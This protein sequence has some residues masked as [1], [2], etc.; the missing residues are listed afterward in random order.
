VMTGGLP[1]I[2]PGVSEAA[3]SGLS[4]ITP[5]YSNPGGVACADED[6]EEEQDDEDACED[7]GGIYNLETCGCYIGP[8][9]VGGGGDGGED[10]PPTVSVSGPSSVAVASSGTSGALNTI[11]I[12]ASGSP[13]GGTYSW[14]ASNGNVSLSNANTASVTVTGVAQG[15]AIVKVTYSSNDQD[16][17]NQQTVNSQQPASVLQNTD[18]GNQAYT[19]H[20]TDG[21]VAYTGVQRTVGYQLYDSASPAAQIQINGIPMVESFSNLNDGCGVGY[22][23]PEGGPTTSGGKF[24]DGFLICAESC[25]PSSSNYKP[26][27]TTTMTHVWTANGFPVFNSTLTYACKS[28]TPQ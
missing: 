23:T 6:P 13:A 5:Q 3:G 14:T 22:P 4:A 28:I 21:T 2:G 8:Y 11:T 27:C 25:D 1:G 24:G 15:S 12:T 10:P 9:P 7:E 18:S 20:F 19:C 26:S 17:T 16:A